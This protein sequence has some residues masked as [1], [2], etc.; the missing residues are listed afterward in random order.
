MTE[1]KRAGIR[2]GWDCSYCEWSD[3]YSDASFLWKGMALY[4]ST[5]SALGMLIKALV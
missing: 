5:L 1:T 4:G 2:G 3:T